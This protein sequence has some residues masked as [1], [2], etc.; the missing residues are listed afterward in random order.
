MELVAIAVGVTTG[1]LLMQVMVTGRLSWV[2]ARTF[3]VMTGLHALVA[4]AALVFFAVSGEATELILGG[5]P[6]GNVGVLADGVSLLMLALVG[7]VGWIV[8]RFSTRY[9]D[10]EA[11]QGRFLRWAAFTV[12]AVSLLVLANNFAL[13]IGAWMLSSLG[14]HQ[15]LTH[16][17]DRP[18]AIR[19]A[20]L[21]FGFSRIGDLFLGLAA[22]IA[23]TQFGTLQITS[24]TEKISSADPNALVWLGMCLAIG[25]MIKTVQFPFHT[26]LPETMEAPTSVSA[27]MHAGVVNAGGYVLIRLSPLVAASVVGMFLLVLIGGI[28]AFGA[29]LV[30]TTQHSVKRKLAWST[31][32]QMGLMILQCGLGAFSAAMLHLVA[33]SMYKAYSFLSSGSVVAQASAVSGATERTENG[34]TS[35]SLAAATLGGFVV[36]AVAAFATG[37][38]VLAKPGGALL[39]VIFAVGMSRLIWSLAQVRNRMMLGLGVAGVFLLS[40]S[41]LGAYAGINALVGPHVAAATFISAWPVQLLLVVAL[42]FCLFVEHRSVT[43]KAT[44]MLEPLRVHAANGFYIDAWQR[45]FNR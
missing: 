11:Q 3:S 42:G 35:R 8:C 10:G 45:T 17:S 41:Y 27:L 31:I 32:A 13:M 34:G 36:F 18:A 16:Y 38:D 15:L 19:A 37:F 33:H 24:F 4:A 25:V 30:M 29:A 44:G 20:K 28:T 2:G 40:L 9:L 6:I 43:G 14:L 23:F 5:T 12:G 39:G 22:L 1:L 7:F 21:K 26:W